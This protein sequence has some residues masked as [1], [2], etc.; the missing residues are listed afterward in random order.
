MVSQEISVENIQAEFVR[1]LAMRTPP[2]ERSFYDDEPAYE[3][4]DAGIDDGYLFC[5]RDLSEVIMG[6]ILV[7]LEPEDCGSDEELN[8]GL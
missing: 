4:H 5:L 3:A 1:L 8:H 7:L 2:Q 6:E